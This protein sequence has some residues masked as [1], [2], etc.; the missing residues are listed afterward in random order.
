MKDTEQ[1]HRPREKTEHI[2]NEEQRQK[3]V[4]TAFVIHSDYLGC[5]PATPFLDRLD[6]ATHVVD[7]LLDL[8]YLGSEEERGRERDLIPCADCQYPFLVFCVRT[9]W[10]DSRTGFL[11]ERCAGETTPI[12]SNLFYT[13]TPDGD[14]RAPGSHENRSDVLFTLVP[15]ESY[16]QDRELISMFIENADEAAANAPYLPRYRFD[17]FIKLLLRWIVESLRV[18][19]PVE[20]GNIALDYGGD[21][22]FTQWLTALLSAGW[23]REEFAKIRHA[24]AGSVEL[25]LP[26][27]KGRLLEFFQSYHI[28]TSPHLTAKENRDNINQKLTEIET[29]IDANLSRVSD[30]K[31]NYDFMTFAVE[32]MNWCIYLLRVGVDPAPYEKTG[33]KGYT[34]HR[35]IIVGHMVRIRKLLCG[36]QNHI[37]RHELELAALFTRP[38]FETSI[39]IEYFI[40]SKAKRKTFRSFILASYKPYKETLQDL[41]ARAKKRPLIQIEK[42]MKRKIVARLTK[43]G[44][45]QTELMNN[46]TWNVD[47]KHFR[48][49]MKQLEQESMYSYGFGS[50][51]DFIHGQWYEIDLHHLNRRGRYY[52]PNFGFAEPDPRIACALTH[53]CLRTL[54]IYLDLKWN[55]SD[56]DGAVTSAVEKLYK[57]NAFLDAVHERSLGE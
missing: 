5:D 42:R 53:I 37:S 26:E 35:A 50:P 39:R 9:D 57:L 36:A 34:K 6:W 1:Q 52:T 19:L 54:L 40:N 4:L 23:T 7:F 20:P 56:P 18:G 44:I 30:C 17:L 49:I 43:D 28:S 29:W 47:G 55:K 12:T 32:I 22:I 15:S 8:V 13:L 46:T 11:V 21:S 33:N 25:T 2:G 41:K 31:T 10:S 27:T 48:D 3:G 24:L 38:I 45:S 16:E 51:S 14:W